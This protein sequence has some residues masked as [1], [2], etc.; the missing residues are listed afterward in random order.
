M[1]EQ[2][3]ESVSTSELYDALTEYAE[4]VAASPRAK[5]TFAAWNCR[6]HILATDTGAEFTFVVAGGAIESVAEGLDGVPELVVRGRS[7]DL[8]EVFWGDASP[9]SNYM[10]GAIRTQGRADDVMRLDAMAM[11]VFLGQ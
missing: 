11:F 5:K 7:M 10:Q 1:S 4:K 3:R 6:V 9:V 8:A 2:T